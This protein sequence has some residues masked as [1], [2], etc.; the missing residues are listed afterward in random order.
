MKPARLS[1]A[2]LAGLLSLLAGCLSTSVGNLATAQVSQDFDTYHIRRV[3]LVPFSGTD[4]DAETELALRDAFLTE[5]GQSTDFEVVKLNLLD[6]EEIPDTE[7]YR[8]GWYE[9]ETIIRV[10]RRYRLDGLIVGTVTHRHPYPP[11][12][13]GIEVDLVAS[14]TGLPV[15]HAAVYLDAADARVRRSLEEYHGTRNAAAGTRES[16]SL[17][18]ISPRRF[19][20]FAAHHVAQLL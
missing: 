5:L 12:A 10:A 4:L 17:T 8:R 14:E 11:Q 3:G 7:P 18:L 1:R 13:L 20:R 15:W 19:A 2:L 16:A 6:L 9:P